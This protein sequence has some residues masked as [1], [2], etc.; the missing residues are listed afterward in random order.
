MMFDQR[1]GGSSVSA[2]WTLKVVGV[3]LCFAAAVTLMDYS[4]LKAAEADAQIKH[5]IIIDAGSSGSRVHVFE[6]TGPAPGEVA[7]VPPEKTLKSGAPLS[8]FE[9]S[10]QNAGG[11]LCLGVYRE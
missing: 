10:T 6:Y 5:F 4:S 3:L 2:T 11:F 7:T 1:V 9:N 8:S